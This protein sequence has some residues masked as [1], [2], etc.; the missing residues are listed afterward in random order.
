MSPLSIYRHIPTVL[1]LNG[2]SLEFTTQ[3]TGVT[4][5]VGLAVTFTGIAT[6]SFSAGTAIEGN[7]AYQ[8]YN[9]TDDS[10]VEDGNRSNSRGGITTFT[11]AGTTSLVILNCQFYED[12]A[13]KY[14][15]QADF[16]P[17]GYWQPGNESPNPNA[18]NDKLNSNIIQLLVPSVLEITSQPQPELEA[19]SALFANF[20]VDATLTD[21]DL[22][23]LI[24]YQWKVNGTNISDDDDTV[25]SKS[26]NLLIKRS[27]G[28]Y[29]LS[30]SVSHPDALPSPILSNEVTYITTS[31]ENTIYAQYFDDKLGPNEIEIYNT[32]A[33]LSLGPLNAPFKETGDTNDRNATTLN[34]LYS[35]DKGLDL[36]IEIAAA[37]GSSYGGNRGGRGGWGLFKLAMQKQVEYSYKLGSNDAS[38]GPW[39]GLIAGSV[40]GTYGGGGA[41]FYRKNRNILTLG[42]GGGAGENG[43]GGDGGGPNQNG[44]D[45]RGS[46]GGVGGEGPPEGRGGDNFTQNVEGQKSAACPSPTNDWLREEY[47]AEDCVHYNSQYFFRNSSRGTDW[48]PESGYRHVN[49]PSPFGKEPLYKKYGTAHLGTKEVPNT[50][51]L[52]RGFRNGNGGRLNGGWGIDGAGGA[53]GAGSDGGNGAS[54][55]GSGGGGASGYAD[56]GQMEILDGRTGVNA[57]DAYLRISLYDPNA[58]LPDPPEST[59][60]EFVSVLWDNGSNTGYRYGDP[61]NIGGSNQTVDGTILY[62]PTGNINTGITT[63]PPTDYATLYSGF[64]SGIGGKGIYFNPTDYVDAD[65]NTK[66][67]GLSYVDFKLYIQDYGPVGGDNINYLLTNRGNRDPEKGVVRMWYTEDPSQVKRYV[68]HPSGELYTTNK[69]VAFVP[70]RIEFELAFACT[71]GGNYRVLYMTK[72][73]DYTTFGQTQDIEFNSAELAAQNNISGENVDGNRLIFPDYSKYNYEN[74]RIVYIR[75]KIINL[76]LDENNSNTLNMY[77]VASSNTTTTGTGNYLEFGKYLQS[78]EVPTGISPTVIPVTSS[79][80]VT[81]TATRSAADSNTVTWTKTTGDKEGPNELTFGPGGGTQAVYI[82][83]GAEYNISS[84]TFSGGRG[85]NQ[86]LSG[87]QTVQFD[88]VGD[89]DYNDL[90]VSVNKGR[91]EGSG[92]TYKAQGSGF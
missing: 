79:V 58:P 43:R 81:W 87:N 66:A 27:A 29:Q 26:K 64:R 71:S 31:V 16:K 28:T 59:P 38:Y 57:G 44:E 25:G 4:T 46:G 47:G 84:K 19:N 77:A 83:A 69:N 48:W 61:D 85:L 14:Y 18:I 39:G 13:D 76:D 40:R 88:D 15:L 7:I 54:S 3:P 62:G 11:G 60:E 41:F 36:L 75:S 10:P 24:E 50:A 82:E 68:E 6:V 30:C 52:F 21:P 90:I 23:S 56:E 34:F 35:P 49:E 12:N 80:L 17:V 53:G 86:R 74:P 8:W 89:N 45:G 2:P 72:S 51:D 73:Y 1:D 63:S 65:N 78:G 67:F 20:N 32:T 92:S 70:F 42:G 9:S 5:T 22:N 33:D 91:F 55:G 37:G